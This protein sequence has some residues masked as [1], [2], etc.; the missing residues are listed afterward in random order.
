MV[1]PTPDGNDTVMELSL[2]RSMKDDG[3]VTLLPTEVKLSD[4]LIPENFMTND[5]L[6][7]PIPTYIH[8]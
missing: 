5:S 3:A 1:I 8:T 7:L 4:T 2:L 6:S